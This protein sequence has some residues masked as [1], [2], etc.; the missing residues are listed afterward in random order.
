VWGGASARWGVIMW[1]CV[2][3]REAVE[4]HFELCW[5]CGTARDGTEDPA[6]R[7]A[8]ELPGPVADEP[9]RR[10]APAP[11]AEGTDTCP[12]CGSPAEHGCVYGSDKGWRLRW[13]AGPPSF[14]ANLATG[15][16]VAEAV[17]GWGFGS[18]PYA[19]GVRC[20]RCRRI[21]LEY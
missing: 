17:G 15:L 3:C 1:T 12:L 8:D 2:K 4:D 20:D 5:S 13:Y 10:R 9:P 14:V 6:F 18:G 16:G 11:V 7:L 19:E 21:I